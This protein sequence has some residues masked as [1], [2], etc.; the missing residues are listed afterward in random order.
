MVRNAVKVLRETQVLIPSRPTQI[1]PYMT[2]FLSILFVYIFPILGILWGGKIILEKK[3]QLSFND[4]F[5][6]TGTPAK[7]FAYTII[8][9]SLFVLIT[10]T[11]LGIDQLTTPQR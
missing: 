8:A 11:I 9:L 2:Y 4:R 3:L 6:I 10:I 5:V 1:A 7:V